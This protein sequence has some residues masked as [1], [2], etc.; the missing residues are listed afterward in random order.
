MLSTVISLSNEPFPVEIRFHISEFY[1]R[2]TSMS[3]SE[4]SIMSE[5][6]FGIM[7][8]LISSHGRNFL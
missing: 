7:M 8:R 1:F 5:G 4:V 6:R 2:M 3:S